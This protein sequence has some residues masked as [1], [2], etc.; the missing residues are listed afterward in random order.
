MK[1]IFLISDCY[2]RYD[3]DCYIWEGFLYEIGCLNILHIHRSKF[4]ITL[5][6]CD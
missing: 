3:L 2:Y 4:P 5:N 6:P 1:K